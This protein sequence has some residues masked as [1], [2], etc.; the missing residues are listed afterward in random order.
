MGDWVHL[1]QNIGNKRCNL[2]KYIVLNTHKLSNV[3]VWLHSTIVEPKVNSK[4]RDMVL[5]TMCLPTKD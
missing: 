5:S 2:I 3:Q 1:T 4:P